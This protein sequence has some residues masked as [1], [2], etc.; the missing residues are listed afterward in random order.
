[1]EHPHSIQQEQDAQSDEHQRANR[2]AVKIHTFAG[3]ECLR[4]SERIGRGLPQRM[5]CAE[6]TESMIW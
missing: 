2:D 1:M 4:Q 3:S 6:R 5:A